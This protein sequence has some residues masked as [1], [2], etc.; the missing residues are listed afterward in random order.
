MTGGGGKGGR[1]THKKRFMG[2]WWDEKDFQM[3]ASP[4][5]RRGDPV[6]GLSKFVGLPAKDPQKLRMVVAVH[7]YHRDRGEAV[8]SPFQ[9]RRKS[10]ME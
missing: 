2:I 7:L 5:C 4:G 6:A 3:P 8:R 10:D 1:E 9:G